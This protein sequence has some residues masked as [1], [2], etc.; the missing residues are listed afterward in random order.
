MRIDNVSSSELL[1]VQQG[2]YNHI[3]TLLALGCHMIG[4]T[5]APPS[6]KGT[7]A[8]R[9]LECLVFTEKLVCLLLK[10]R[11]ILPDDNNSFNLRSKQ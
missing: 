8:Q 2:T 5:Y 10:L 3:V 7:T 11:F 6:A 9:W 1:S 4:P